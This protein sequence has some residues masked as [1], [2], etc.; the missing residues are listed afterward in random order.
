MQGL[1][2]DNAFASGSID[3]LPSANEI[4][5]IGN[6][7]LGILIEAMSANNATDVNDLLASPF[8]IGDGFDRFLDN[9][10]VVINNQIN[11]I[12]NQTFGTDSIQTT[13]V[14]NVDL[15]H[16]FTD[17][18]DSAPSIPQNL[19]ALAASDSVVVV[20]WEPSS[21]DKGVAGYHV[22]RDGAL[23]ATTPFPVYTDSNLS[24]GVSYSYTVEAFDGREQLSGQTSTPATFTLATP[25]TTS[26]SMASS[27]QI[28]EANNSLA[29]SWTISDIGDVQGFRIYRGASG[30]VNTSGSP[31]AVITSTAFQDFDVTPGS[32][33]CYRI[34]T[35]DAVNNV[36]EPT[37][38][39]CITTSGTS[40]PSVV[41]FSSAN[42]SVDETQSTVTISVERSGDLSESISVDYSVTALSAT[43]G[44]D[45]TETSGTLN[46]SATDSSAKSFSVQIAQDSEVESDETVELTLL[47]PSANTSLGSNTSATLTISDAP[48]VTCIDLSTTDITT[49]TTLSEP[50]YN[51]TSNVSVSNNATLTIDPGVR[52][53]FSAGTR[54]SIRSDGLLLAVGTQAESIIFTSAMQTAGYWDG[55]YIDSVGTSM[56]EYT[57]V[58]YGGG[59][60]SYTTANVSLSSQGSLSLNNS[61]VRH[62]KK[63]GV[64]IS[65]TDGT[66]IS[67]FSG[68][69]VTLNEDA[70]IY[71]S[72]DLMGNIDEDNTLTGNITSIG[73]DN[74]YVQLVTTVNAAGVS[75]D[76]TWHDVAIDYHMP[77]GTTSIGAALTIAPG[78]NLVFPA[79]AGLEIQA[80]G[81]LIASGT[82]SEP[83]TF[84]GQQATPGFWRGIQFSF[85]HTDNIMEHAIVEYGGDGGN[86]EAN[87]GV[88]GSDGRLTIR[89]SVLRH[90][91]VNGFYFADG[92]TLTMQNV[93]ISG[94]ERPGQVGFY[95]LGLLDKNSSYSG[96]SDDRL[97]VTNN[98]TATASNMT[99]PKLDVPYYFNST[100]SIGV[101]MEMTI[102]PGVELQFNAGG[103]LNVRNTGA[104]IAEGTPG[105]PITFTGAVKTKGYWNGIQVTFSNIATIFDYTIVEYGGAPIGNTEA[106]IGYFGSD[107]NG[108]VTNSVLRSSQTNGI[109]LSSDTSGEFTTGNTFDDIDGENVYRA[110]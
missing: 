85:N 86:T 71:I 79:G 21:D 46:W 12:I 15:N 40:A 82:S 63:Y 100:T 84:T 51:V 77:E 93:T 6:E 61:I 80:A 73:G 30:S 109:W 55:I 7:F 59:T 37:P 26:P 35:F 9:S 49:D 2:I 36:S 91:A 48:Q 43:A 47:N 99:V 32:T 108:S 94:N 76:Q 16:D 5:A 54:L 107:T 31:L 81:T 90:S 66:E 98:V 4:E 75:N 25:D 8:V 97:L 10:T 102:E 92:I 78:V 96:N 83:I 29:L 106:L 38:E 62:S 1:D 28:D 110:P 87:V 105:E 69:T 57:V 101:P 60:T 20:V 65:P 13:L 42:Y 68:N 45:F 64:A 17:S 50:C 88:F 72:T 22:Y 44:V 53:V 34:I 104:L 24:T 19:R 56:L 3:A 70:P 18:L 89:D 74:D 14:D 27:V 67:S 103:G 95:S 11:I 41:S 23:I 33:Y 39:S 58:E 52:M